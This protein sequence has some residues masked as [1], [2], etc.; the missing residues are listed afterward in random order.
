[1]RS[2]LELVEPAQT[3]R[4]KTRPSEDEKQKGLRLSPFGTLALGC[5]VIL[6]VV[7]AIKRVTAPA[8]A[9]EVPP[10]EVALTEVT[11]TGDP[12]HIA[13]FVTNGASRHIDRVTF[14]LIYGEQT[15]QQRLYF[16]VCDIPPG[17]KKKGHC[18]GMG[19]VTPIKHREVRPYR[20]EWTN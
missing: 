1:M 18:L 6:L 14:E 12:P 11:E 13:G 8:V 10:H 20:I 3:H 17:A 15:Q 5:V 2:K 7:L 16:T 19:L 4:K 9:Y